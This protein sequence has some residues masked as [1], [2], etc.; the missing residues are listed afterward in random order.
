[1]GRD[2]SSHSAGLSVTVGG[3]L[4][5]ALLVGYFV[6]GRGGPP[7][8]VD[9]KVTVDVDPPAPCSSR[10]AACGWSVADDPR[11][12]IHEAVRSARRG[13]GNSDPVYAFVAT[14]SGYDQDAVLDQLRADLPPGARIHG[15]TSA[16]GIMTNDGFHRGNVGAA[17]V[18]LVA[19]P[20]VTFG[21]SGVNLAD[22]PDPE[23]AGQ[24]AVRQAY[25]DAGVSPHIRPKIIIMTGT[26]A[27]PEQMKLLGGIARVAGV[28]TP[29]IG[30]DAADDG[31]DGGWRQFTRDRVH[32]NGLGVV[33]T[34]V[35]TQAKAGWS[36]EH[37]FR[38][39]DK[40]G[41]VTRA[42]G[43]VI[44][45]IDHRPALEV[46]NQWLNGYLYDA[47]MTKDFYGIV[48]FTGQ[49]PLCK[50]LKG[51]DGQIG[52]VTS[53]PLPSRGNLKDKRLPVA[54]AIETGSPVRLFA[55][56]WQTILNRAEY[57]P[58]KALIQGG[59]T[60]RDC[61]WGVVFFCRGASK[62]I[63]SGELPKVP[64]LVNNSMEDVPFVGLITGG[65]Q[66]P[67]PGIGNVHANLAECM[68]IV[69][70]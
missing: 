60:I 39:T 8:A 38:I 70:K 40:E 2:N 12:A 66:G 21:V 62:I 45:E 23:M 27:R 18:L 7:A 46:Y 52:Y 50:V 49:N 4:L 36:F 26:K 68:A 41:R 19:G 17:A 51:K 3:V 10:P 14:T 31:N 34:V 43:K 37:G 47:L 24:E 53:H 56:T 61:A 6:R 67:V 59:L 48:Q 35:F 32:H 11:Q 5:A 16:F 63:P 65:E 9:A 25:R 20:D 15:A 54:A 28:D 22:F 64:L 30:G 58:T 57:L 29:V 55:G 69:G 33:L 44:H 1:M 13:V 42:E